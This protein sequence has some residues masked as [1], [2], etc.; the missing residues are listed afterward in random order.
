MRHFTIKLIITFILSFVVFALITVFSYTQISKSFIANQATVQLIKT[1]DTIQNRID[2]QIAFD[3]EN[4]KTMIIQFENEDL[5][6]VF[7]LNQNIEN[8][9]ANG[10]NY[11]SFGTFTNDTIEIKGITY[12]FRASYDEEDYTEKVQI[13]TFN[14]AFGSGN[15]DKKLMFRINDYLA[16]LNL[17][18]YF[19]GINEISNLPFIY[20]I[21]DKDNFIYYDSIENSSTRFL[22][23][24]LRSEGVSEAEIQ[25]VIEDVLAREPFTIEKPFLGTDSYYT[26]TPMSEAYSSKGFFLV[27]IYDEEDVIG[28]L[29]L[30]SSTLIAIFSAIFVVYSV[31]LFFLYKLVERKLNDI[32]DAKIAHYYAKPYIMRIN[33]NGK[34][35]S[36]N[37][38]LSNAL[39]ENNYYKHV[40]NFKVSDRFEKDSIYHMIDTQKAFTLI[41]EISVK[42]TLYVRFIPLRVS[43]G[44]V[45]IGE[46]ITKIEGPFE[47]YRELA[48][49][50]KTTNLPNLN[51]L[52][53]DLQELFDDPIGFDQKNAMVA[54]DIVSFNKINLLLG[55]KSGDRFLSIFSEIVKQSLEGYPA[56]L[57]NTR[58]DQFVVLFRGIEA[59]D[60]TIKWVEKLNKELDKPI[61]IERSF[62]KVDIKAGI[63]NMESQKY[64]IFNP[65]VCIENAM[66]A[67]NH[68]KES[69]VHVYF[70]YD[71]S[72][73][74]IASRDQGMEQDL[75]IAI[76]KREFYL[77]MQP[78]Y[79]NQEHKIIGFEALVRWN[80]PKYR[81]ES[82][83][84]FIEMAEAN[85]MIIDIGRIVIEETC[86]IAK[87]L[88]PYGVDISFNVSP[89]QLLQAGFVN[90]VIRIFEEYQVKKGM[91]SIE[92]TETFLISS[93]ELVINKLRLLRNYGFNIH[94][95]D[96]GS[97]YSSLQYLRDLPV[98]ALKIDKEF[99]KDIENDQHSRAIVTMISNL[100]KSI[101]L[102][103]IAEGI[104]NDRQNQLVIKSG[105]N[106]IQGYYIS[107]P[108]EKEE[109]LNLIKAYNIDKTKTVEQ[110]RSTRTR[111]VKR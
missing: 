27:T 107:R 1:G 67:L 18:D 79:S 83:Q 31:S 80:N 100:A 38:S 65:E 39:K 28:S 108:V 78:Q 42:K 24:Y 73:S 19:S 103:V 104:E 16:I 32:E 35:K 22:Y 84:K 86:K 102:E 57:Y 21:M 72:L 17:D 81:G 75:A 109:A 97:G 8:I 44:F 98:N 61:T 53:Y 91:V 62:L 82:P 23:D 94:L 93:F 30:L 99:I 51:S 85:N 69:A 66:L 11:D 40:D 95:D 13:F 74:L 25:G 88:E 106:I 105:C 47:Q 33:R 50:S 6:P 5:D 111:E 56:K 101:G 54:F 9:Y 71:V 14:N 26:F 15:E 96:F 59:Y 77:V 41:F 63:F 90:E 46:D 110:P 92:V 37:R 10:I 58:A 89:V 34:V 70:T 7:Q 60:W 4:L 43:G 29:S 55:E 45:L 87:E 36:M 52:K 20:V 49:F 12:K 76:Q 3:Y 64:E 48:L 2:N 68:A